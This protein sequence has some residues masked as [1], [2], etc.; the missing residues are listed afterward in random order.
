MDDFPGLTS[1]NPLYS[2][3]K[4]GP[5]PVDLGK[6]ID[7]MGP[8]NPLLGL[9]AP[10]RFKAE[11]EVPK[12]L[13]SM[14]RSEIPWVQI[15]GRLKDQFQVDPERYR[16]AYQLREAQA[17][18]KGEGVGTLEQ[19]LDTSIPFASDI[20]TARAE[21]KYGE[22]VKRFNAGEAT[23][24]DAMTIARHERKQEI[25]H[26]RSTGEAV[27]A[28]AGKIPALLG[29]FGIGSKV[30]RGLGGLL[31]AG[32]KASRVLTGTGLLPRAVQGAA[33]TPFTTGYLPAGQ[34]SLNENPDQ[35][36]VQAYGPAFVLTASQNAILGQLQGALSGAHTRAGRI[37]GKTV[38]GL[39]ES[40]VADAGATLLDRTA[41][42]ITGKTLGLDTKW[43]PLGQWV[44]A[45]QGGSPS[46]LKDARKQ[47]IVHFATFSLFSAMHSGKE[48]SPYKLKAAIDAAKTPE[49]VAEVGT[50]VE[51]AVESAVREIMADPSLRDDLAAANRLIAEKVRAKFEPDE[52]PIGDLGRAYADSFVPEIRGTPNARNARIDARSETGVP[53]VRRLTMLKAP[54][55]E[56]R[57]PDAEV[58]KVA[59]T[60]Q[61]RPGEASPEPVPVAEP[62]GDR[63]AEPVPGVP[64]PNFPRLTPQEAPLGVPDTRRMPMMPRETSASR[65]RMLDRLR[66]KQGNT[67]PGPVD[68]ASMAGPKKGS[69]ANPLKT[70]EVPAEVKPITEEYLADA[71]EEVAAAQPPKRSFYNRV[72]DR[73]VE[74]QGKVGGQKF[75][76]AV[77]AMLAAGGTRSAAEYIGTEK[78]LPK[79]P[80][81]QSVANWAKES[82]RQLKAA[83]P[84]TFG[85][86]KT[87][88]E[89]VGAIAQDNARLANERATNIANGELT[90]A[91]V[92]QLPE[93]P[94]ER[95]ALLKELDRAGRREG[96]VQATELAAERAMYRRELDQALQ[97]GR[98][99]ATR[100]AELV[101]ELLP[102][103]LR[104]TEGKDRGTQPPRRGKPA[105]VEPDQPGAG[106]PAQAKGAKAPPAEVPIVVNEGGVPPLRDQSLAGFLRG[107]EGYTSEAPHQFKIPTLR[108]F[109]EGE[110]GAAWF[111]TPQLFREMTRQIFGRGRAKDAPFE[112]DKDT[113][114]NNPKALPPERIITRTAHNQIGARNSTLPEV[115]TTAWAWASDAARNIA[116][117]WRNLFAKK[118]DP[119]AG[120]PH[121][122]IIEEEIR[123]PGSQ[124]LNPEQQFALD[125]W[126][127]VWEK[128]L[129]AM[130]AEGIKFY[131]DHGSRKTVDDMLKEGYF[132]RAAIKPTAGEEAL[133]RLMGKKP[134]VK[135]G[136]KIERQHDSQ[137]DAMAKGVQYK[138]VWDAMAEF[139]ETSNRHIADQRLANDKKLGG[140]DLVA[141]VRGRL[142]A[143]NK[144]T[145]DALRKADPVEA[146]RLERRLSAMA[147]QMATGNVRVAPA[148]KGKIYP[149][150]VKAWLEAV[151]GEK[152]GEIVKRFAHWNQEIRNIGLGADASYL[153]L[154]MLPMAF[155]NPVRFLK[156]A[157]QIPKA[158]VD[159]TL[160]ATQAAKRPEIQQAINEIV[161]GGG[162]ISQPPDQVLARGQS[163]L[164]KVPGLGKVFDTVYGRAS[165]AM[166]QILDLAKI[167]LYLANKPAD[168]KQIPRFV[169]SL[170]NSLGQGRME[171]LGMTPERGLLERLVFLAPS[172][173]RAHLASARQAFQGGAAGALARKQL[174]GLM[175]G[176]FLTS[177]AALY[178]LKSQNQISEEEFEERLNP[179]RGKFLMVPVPLGDD[180]N[181]EIGF[182]GLWTSVARTLGNANRWAKGEQSD[183]PLV[184]W[185]RGH[186]GTIIRSGWDVGEGKDYLGQPTGIGETAVKLAM[187]L[188][189]QPLAKGALEQT[190]LIDQEATGLQRLGEAGGGVVGLRSHPGSPSGEYL[191]RLR[192]AAPIQFG[193]RYE[194]L[195]FDQQAKLVQQFGEMKPP[196]T[197]GAKTAALQQDELRAKRLLSKMPSDVKQRLKDVGHPAV[198][199]YDPEQS[200]A[201]VRVPLTQARRERYETLLAEEY[202]RA[203]KSWPMDRVKEL[204]ATARKKFV[205]SSFLQAKQRARYRLFNDK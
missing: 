162:T 81:H 85:Q 149:P 156:T 160:L 191:D 22:A 70:G 75:A 94:V 183:N 107:D 63:P 144:D 105:A 59:E 13:D 113:N 17:V 66:A 142:F 8:D 18:Q 74:N 55:G 131:D 205:D 164:G 195:S 202:E 106:D 46:E 148:F 171:K 11:V 67:R 122:D 180:K 145:L 27:L 40:Q 28:E 49:Q 109:M 128:Q 189:A 48:I 139:I 151:Y 80:S 140:V 186:A 143:E 198:P 88:E 95:D 35:N 2:L 192:K 29:E 73:L 201:G 193:K 99:D 32:T 111:P 24:E 179:S 9:V 4:N 126:K 52:T 176:V 152:S 54:G 45:E 169:E 158:F 194:D 119:F 199:S 133:G 51:T 90:E 116:N 25:E 42:A 10:Q 132:H 174:G 92:K 56:R 147:G 30:V 103:R 170:E 37:L 102:R 175:S 91:D 20:R 61:D 120:L 53:D 146:G 87:M 137:A 38:V 71:A 3:I 172:F 98:L 188:A 23:G 100:H 129:R 60:P 58:D 77:Q 72:M 177:L 125:V 21:K 161:Q 33:V 1:D 89:L 153:F 163:L 65:M 39:G 43:G 124:K 69:P 15:E 200:I 141:K 14:L 115:A 34:R 190:G 138:G 165:Q 114:P 185:Y 112:F 168:P 130:D 154:Q 93:D 136:F 84:E 19:F 7:R 167:E 64:R 47:A 159:G 68:S 184:R 108:E 127:G 173:Y 31:P 204:P 97:E 117:A 26:N 155:T 150:E 110:S 121:A 203:V 96:V 41:K 83:D 196:A 187:P 197:E 118:A 104:G 57:I 135:P 44:A 5:D 123:N 82:L 16:Q 157:W 134:G 6:E 76:A 62:A 178:A 181:L 182:G 78:L 166:T 79:Q 101:R 12:Y 50:Q 36:I 86:Y